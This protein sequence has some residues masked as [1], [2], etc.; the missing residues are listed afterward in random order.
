LLSVSPH[1][2][3]ATQAM[4]PTGPLSTLSSLDC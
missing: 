3:Q 2:G 4:P 1:R